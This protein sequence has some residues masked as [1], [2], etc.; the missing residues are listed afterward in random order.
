[1]VNSALIS[2]DEMWRDLQRRA[3]DPD[4]VSRLGD[5][6]S[7]APGGDLA[8]MGST[9]LAILRH[10]P[11]GEALLD[12]AAGKLLS[13]WW[14][15]GAPKSPAGDGLGPWINGVEFIADSAAIFKFSD[16][17][18]ITAT[19]IKC[20][21]EAW[22]FVFREPPPFCEERFDRRT[23]EEGVQRRATVTRREQSRTS[24]ATDTATPSPEQTPPS[25]NVL[26]EIDAGNPIPN[27]RGPEGKKRAGAA[28]S[29]I[30][31]VRERKI[32][33]DDLRRLKQKELDK[34]YPAQRTT[35]VAARKDAL[36]ELQQ[37]SDKTP[38]NDK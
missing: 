27:K 25:L 34:F 8:R 12:G 33:V 9:L 13:S 35:L 11:S 3:I 4:V 15:R 6:A 38:T 26:R 14:R 20:D 28:A 7:H 5:G 29:M 18:A 31:A 21:R 1:M 32:T 23:F 30:E 17:S 16:G 22:N 36:L 37:N 19:A 24:E 10:L 2:L